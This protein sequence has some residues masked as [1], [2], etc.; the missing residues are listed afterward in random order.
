MSDP[1]TEALI[2][3]ARRAEADRLALEVI[4]AALKAYGF[5]M[6]ETFGPELIADRAVWVIALAAHNKTEG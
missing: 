6:A 1:T 3:F 4:R 2:A 5:D